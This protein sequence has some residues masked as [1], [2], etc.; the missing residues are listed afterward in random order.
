MKRNNVWIGAISVIIGVRINRIIGHY[1]GESGN[2]IL[3][4][5]VVTFILI[6]IV[7]YI[8]KKKY[9]EAARYFSAGLPLTIGFTGLLLNN[10]YL[11]F[12]GPALFLI[13]IPIMIK[14]NARYK[15]D[16]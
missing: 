11:S 6:S 14:V 7:Y 15:N 9:L 10:D 16:N 8:F 3:V 13:T 5:S 12:G 1:Y 4:G 2:N